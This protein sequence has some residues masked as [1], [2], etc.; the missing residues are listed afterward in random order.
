MG[1]DLANVD[2]NADKSKKF[3]D[4][5]TFIGSIGRRVL[6]DDI[7]P[8][9]LPVEACVAD[10]VFVQFVQVLR[11]SGGDSRRSGGLTVEWR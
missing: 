2:I 10:F 1:R 8:V 4:F 7:C 3:K 9:R 5:F 6:G 11:W